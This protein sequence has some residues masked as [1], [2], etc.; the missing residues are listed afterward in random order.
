[1]GVENDLALEFG[2]KL[3]F[4]TPGSELTWYLC[5]GPKWLGFSVGIG[6]DLVYVEIKLFLI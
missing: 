5:S 3:T 6:I 4:L 2:S 1:M